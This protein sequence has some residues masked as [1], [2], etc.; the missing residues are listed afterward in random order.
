MGRLTKYIKEQ[1]AEI[2]YYMKERAK[3]YCDN[4]KKIPIDDLTNIDCDKYPVCNYD[5]NDLANH[6][7]DLGGWY[8]LN[9]VLKECILSSK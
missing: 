1:I 9:N 5:D 6:N 8:Q 3:D 4:V 7:F 2:E